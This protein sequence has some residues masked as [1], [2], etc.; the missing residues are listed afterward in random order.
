MPSAL[1]NP[2][3]SFP[4]TRCDDGSL[5]DFNNP[6]APIAGNSYLL[7]PDQYLVPLSRQTY[8]YGIAYHL[9]GNTT[10]LSYMKAGIDYI[11]QN[12]IDPSG[13]MFEQQDLTTGIWGP[14]IQY[15]RPQQLGYGLLGMAFYYYLTRDQTVLPDI[16]AIKNYIFDSYY[17]PSL[18]VMQW[19]LADDNGTSATSKNLVADLDQMNTYLVLLTPTLPEPYQTQWKQTLALDAHS[20][21]GTYYSPQ[22]DIIFRMPILPKAPI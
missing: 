17:N 11:R 22:D 3:G 8:G 1:G 16:L 19:L 12:L 4:S 15:R 7:L 20:I 18:G 5:L 13:G 21:L 2:I 10:Y 14:G 9:T 6:C